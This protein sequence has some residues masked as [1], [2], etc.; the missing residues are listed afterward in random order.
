M[1][2]LELVEA[3]L[4][5]YVESHAKEIGSIL[6]CGVPITVLSHKALLGAMHRLGEF[7]QNMFREHQSNLN[8]FSKR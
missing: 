4:S 6:Y 5:E 1:T 7:S 8:A 3:E 2:N